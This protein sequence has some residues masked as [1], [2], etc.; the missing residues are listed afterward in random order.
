M[1]GFLRWIGC[2][3]TRV[4]LIVHARSLFSILDCIMHCNFVTSTGTC[5]RPVRQGSDR[6]TNHS[7]DESANRSYRIS[8]PRLKEAVSYHA[9]AS[10][11]DISQQIITLKAIIERRLNMAGSTDAEQ[12]AAFNFVASQLPAL[13]KLTESMVK[14]SKDSG[15]LMERAEVL[16]Y[17][18][19]IIGIVAEEIQ[20]LEGSEDI[21]DRIVS[22][23]EEE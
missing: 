15:E 22:R 13:A 1:Q 20:G 4:F 5:G 3:L 17:T 10:L 12:I 23:L 2:E 7:R 16:E 18:S 9:K 8:D 21:I 11:L 14:L 6:C 19:K